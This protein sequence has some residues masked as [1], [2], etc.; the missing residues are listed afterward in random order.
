MNKSITAKYKQ[1]L[2]N[3]PPSLN[4]KFISVILLAHH[5]EDVSSDAA[6][7]FFK[8]FTGLNFN[9]IRIVA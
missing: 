9:A 5:N 6:Q 7:I 3:V 2:R 4:I 1:F 8:I